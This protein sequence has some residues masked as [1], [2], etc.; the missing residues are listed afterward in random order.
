MRWPRLR[1]A[2]FYW[3]GAGVIG[4][5]IVHILAVFAWPGFASRGLFERVEQA[6]PLN[7]LLVLPPAEPDSQLLPFM[8][9]DVR[10]AL[11]RFDLTDGPVSLRTSFLDGTWSVALYDGRGQNFYAVSGNDLKRRD[12]ELL[13]AP[14]DITGIGQLPIA[15]DQPASQITVAVPE[16]RG[17]LV[18][19]APLPGA[20][21]AAD[22][23]RLLKASSCGPKGQGAPNGP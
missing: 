5:A 23:E 21:Y 22:S 10:Y 18:I 2:T 19:R 15:R 9:P 13:L 6:T 4:A 17:L 20:A 12:I 11:C 14:T 7:E 8:A 16:R 1:I 3:A